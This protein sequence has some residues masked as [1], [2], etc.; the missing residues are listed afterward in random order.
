MDHASLRHTIVTSTRQLAKA[1][2]RHKGKSPLF[3]SWKCATLSIRYFAK[4]LIIWQMTSRISF[5]NISSCWPQSWYSAF[6]SKKL[7]TISYTPFRRGK[8]FWR[9]NTFWRNDKWAKWRFLAKRFKASKIKSPCSCYGTHIHDSTTISLLDHKF[10]SFL[11]NKPAAIK[12]YS[13]HLFIRILK[14]FH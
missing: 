8:A 3:S 4:N 5:N 7:L 10:D 1:I 14:I 11:Q 12:V 9:G 6:A 13:N 2:L